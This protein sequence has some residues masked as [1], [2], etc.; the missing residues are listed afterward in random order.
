MI[1]RYIKLSA[2]AAALA[3]TLAMTNDASAELLA[4]E[5]FDYDPGALS[6]QNGGDGWGGSWGAGEV[7]SGSLGYGSLTTTGNSALFEGSNSYRLLDDAY[8]AGTYYISFVGLRQSPHATL[9]ENVIRASSF[10]IHHSTG[11]ERL[12]AG[13]TT[14]ASP[15]VKYNWAAFSDGSGD[16]LEE[17][18]TPITEQ[19]FILLEV[20][21]ADDTNGEGP[22]VSSDVARMWVN[23]SLDGPLGV[24]DV[25]LN[26]AD[27]NNH[28]YL[29]NQIRV[30]AGGSNSAGPAAFF[31][32]DEI[33]IGTTLGDVT[34]VVPE[35]TTAMLGLLAAVAGLVARRR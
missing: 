8:G 23:P 30:F 5:G 19:A 15:D 17:S 28:D 7:V 16:F 3:A 26:Q 34:P 32:I 33:R 31:A 4:Y 29:F 13:K 25:E 24:A 20:V 18:S 35:P 2:C 12:G 21:V 27:G 9:D 22:G 11:D 6:G 10:Q 1:G 14:T